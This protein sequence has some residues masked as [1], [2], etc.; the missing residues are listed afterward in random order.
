M[1]TRD[2]HDRKAGKYDDPPASSPPLGIKRLGNQDCV[3]TARLHQEHLSVGLFPQL[4]LRFLSRWHRT[5]IA[6]PHGWGA[7]A[8]DERAQIVGF[9][10]VATDVEQY[11]SEVLSAQRWRLGAAGVV[12]LLRRPSVAMGFARTRSRRYAKRLLRRRSQPHRG[13]GSPTTPTTTAVVYAMV[14]AP[15]ARGRGVGRDLLDAAVQAARAAGATEVRLLTRSRG[16]A[17]S[18][19]ENL[20]SGAAGFYEHL[21]WHRVRQVERDGS[22]LVE[23]RLPLR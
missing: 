10:L 2:Q 4:G 19:T 20:A 11:V 12:A 9:V 23:Y 22:V 14:T 1:P 17:T 6:A 15:A 8:V 7:V 21:D 3:V 5:F 18:P 13:G 16:P